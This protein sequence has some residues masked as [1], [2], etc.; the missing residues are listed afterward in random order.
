[1]FRGYVSF[2]EGSMHINIYPHPPTGGVGSLT[3][4]FRRIQGTY[5]SIYANIIKYIYI[6]IH[7]FRH[8]EIQSEYG[9]LLVN[10]GAVSC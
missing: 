6:Y 5:L 7:T 3:G 2:R 1:M 8:R 4:F 10:V 9:W